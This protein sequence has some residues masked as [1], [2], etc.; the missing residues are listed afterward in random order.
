MFKNVEKLGKKLTKSEQ[1]TVNGGVILFC[2]T[3][4]DCYDLDPTAS[5]GDYSCV[6]SPYGGYGYC[7]YN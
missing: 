4:Q 1:K 2:S 6:R 7:V 3:W 5:I